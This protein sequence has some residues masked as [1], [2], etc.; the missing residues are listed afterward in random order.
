MGTA[1]FW[2]SKMADELGRMMVN[3]RFRPADLAKRLRVV[4]EKRYKC[5]R[6]PVN[7]EYGSNGHG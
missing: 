2:L 7:S 6:M 5:D 1:V 4:S 3:R